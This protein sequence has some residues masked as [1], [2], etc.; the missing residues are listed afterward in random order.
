M[1]FFVIALIGTGWAFIKPYLTERDRN[2]LLIV[3]PL[4][5]ISNAALIYVEETSPGSQE[6][7]TLISFSLFYLFSPFWPSLYTFLNQTLYYDIFR[8]V[9]IICCVAILVPIMGSIKHLQEA[10]QVD[11]KGL[12]FLNRN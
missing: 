10:A 3:I 6:W 4:Q 2:V 11:G 1:F 7:F 8:L 5:V 9:D 12:F